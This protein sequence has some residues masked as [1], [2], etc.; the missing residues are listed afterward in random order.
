MKSLTIQE[1]RLSSYLDK[2]RWTDKGQPITLRQRLDNMAI[3]GKSTTVE[4]YASKKMNGCYGKL[5]TPKTS[6]FVDYRVGA[7]DFSL[8]I[9]KIVFDFILAVEL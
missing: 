6:Y 2:A 9:P 4:K 3:I 7:D 1:K 8:S 5:A